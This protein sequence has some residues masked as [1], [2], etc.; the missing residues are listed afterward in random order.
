MAQSF[1]VSTPQGQGFDAQA[2]Q[3]EI[4]R[5]RRMADILRQQSAQPEGQMVSGRFVA[6]S[7][8]QR[9]AG[10][11]NAYQSG[12]VDR[13]AGEQA[14][15]LGQ[16]VDE[17]RRS[18]TS[19]IVAALTGGQRGVEGMPDETGNPTV[20][21]EAVQGDPRRAAMLAAGASSPE[22]RAFLPSL[23]GALTPKQ[24]EWKLGER[25]NAQTGQ[26][27]K[28]MYNAANPQQTMPVGGQRASALE[29]VNEGGQIVPRD[30]YTAAPV[31]AAIPRT[32]TPGEVQASA[33]APFLA[34][35]GQV[36]PNVPVQQLK[37][38]VA[39]AGGTRIN[40]P[41]SVNTATRPMLGE[42]GKAVGENVASAFSAAQGAGK[43]LQV[44]Q[45]VREG[46]GNAIIGPAANARIK[47]A[48]VGQMLGV[49]GA[50]AGERLANTRS[51]I[52]GLAQQELAAAAQMKGQ[53]AL[54]DAER[55]ILRRAAS[56]EIQDLTRAELKMLM[57]SA[58]RTARFTM[59]THER[60][61]ARIR[62]D[63]NLA[64]V[65]GF[66]EIGGG[67]PSA[68]QAPPAAPS[69]A[70]NAAE[71]AELADLRRRLGNQR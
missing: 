18:E 50:D 7:I 42:I 15:S 29:F 56:G 32:L 22:A 54:T 6:P 19:G 24:V 38:D 62:T 2:E 63:P 27:E 21:M 5:R 52:Q 13:Q 4:A 26:P 31:G 20:Q 11:F 68:P 3:D 28:F 57:D 60:N 53:G 41:V 43:T 1:Q 48:Q 71:Q 61:M 16:R 64:G 40:M 33:N 58:E 65:A 25:F 30:R 12:Q 45:Q 10:L 35:D 37:R 9:L 36:V 17:R 34:R 66:M 23:M 59:G 39:A 8:T 49:T 44:V 46:M 70:L 55:G 69:G 14:R 47:L 67:Q 51:V